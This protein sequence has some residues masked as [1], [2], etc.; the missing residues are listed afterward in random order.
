MQLLALLHGRQF[1]SGPSASQFNVVTYSW[2]E[3]HYSALALKRSRNS[4]NLFAAHKSIYTLPISNT[5]RS[6]AWFVLQ[7]NID[8]WSCL[9]LWLI[10]PGSRNVAESWPSDLPSDWLSQQSAMFQMTI[11]NE[12]VAAPLLSA[13]IHLTQFLS[14]D[15]LL[16]ARL[17]EHFSKN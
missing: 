3:H 15:P 16:N 7:Q 9:C 10:T 4:K 11:G 8:L 1:S 13:L 6:I 14:Q 12:C 2:V 17:H 5:T